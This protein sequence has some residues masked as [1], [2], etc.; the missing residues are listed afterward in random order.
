MRLRHNKTI[1]YKSK[2]NG[3]TGVLY[4]RSSLT[5]YNKDGK[6]VMHTGFRNI[7]TYEE[8]VE[9][10]ETFPEFFELLKE[11]APKIKEDFQN[12]VDDDDF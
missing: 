6:E 7:N 8:L 2:K 3:Y 4:G 10:V 5:I 12:G 9:T 1:K 11:A